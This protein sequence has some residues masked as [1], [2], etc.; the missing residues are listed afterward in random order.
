MIRGS[1]SRYKATNINSQSCDSDYVKGVVCL[2]KA[3]RKVQA[4]YPLVVAVL[5]DVP[6][7]HRNLVLNQG[8]LLHEIDPVIPPVGDKESP[9]VRA[10]FAINYCKLRLWQFVEYRKMIY[11]DADI[12]VLKNIDSLFELPSGRF[13]AVMDCLCEMGDVCCTEM[14]Q[15][16]QVLGDKPPFYFN[17]GMFIFEPSLHT[18]ASLLRSLR[19]TPPTP[20]AE[21]DFLNA[22]FKSIAK[23]LHHVYNL[24]VAMLWRHP[25][26]VQLD[27]VKVVHFCV[28][29]SKPWKY[30]GT[31]PYMDRADLKMLVDGWWDVYNDASLD[32]VGDGAGPSGQVSG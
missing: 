19:T 20:F 32:F 7:E 17:G 9:F 8:C 18:Y 31:E 30:T 28:A 29:G 16:P 11:M 23:P 5:P 4:A 27:E 26:Y 13:Y 25:E 1:G 10:Y 22:F 14:V 12:H 21:Q 24:L 3:L 2:A 6:E 15:W